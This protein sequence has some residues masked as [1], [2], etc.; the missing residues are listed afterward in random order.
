MSQT[1]STTKSNQL[2]LRNRRNNKKYKLEIKKAIKRYL[3]SV[4]NQSESNVETCF[5]Y[6]SIVY[7]KID[8]A[9]NKKVLHKN[10]GS[11]KKSRLAKIM[12]KN[13]Y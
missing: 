6:L 11:R 3:L 4:E 12:K 13:N 5:N 10:T 7:Q 1:L 8:K 9:I 2:N